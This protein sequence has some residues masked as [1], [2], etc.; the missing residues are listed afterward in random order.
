MF[1]TIKFANYSIKP[2]INTSKCRFSN[3]FQHN[4]SDWKLGQNIT[5]RT[6][7]F[8]CKCRK[9]PVELFLFSGRIGSEINRNTFGFAIVIGSK[10]QYFRLR[11]SHRNI[12]LFVT[13]NARYKETFGIRSARFPIEIDSIINFSLIIFAKN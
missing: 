8:Y 5:H 3:R 6:S 11:I 10:I 4:F 1:I 13:S 12:V 9:I 2:N 7:I